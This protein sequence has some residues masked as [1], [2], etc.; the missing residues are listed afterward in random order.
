MDD[1]ALNQPAGRIE[2]NSTCKNM[3][4]INFKL[5]NLV[6]FFCPRSFFNFNSLPTLLTHYIMQ[7][8]WLDYVLFFFMYN[9]TDAARELEEGERKKKP[10][11]FALGP[12]FDDFAK[13]T[14]YISCGEFVC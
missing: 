11:C 5:P 3:F 7:M 4:Y 13:R 14:Y 10:N 8:K 9:T 2:L 12:V 1:I 6:V